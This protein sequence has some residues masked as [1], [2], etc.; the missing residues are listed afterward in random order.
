VCACA[1]VF[2]CV[3]RRFNYLLFCERE[4]EERSDAWM[5]EGEACRKRGNAAFAAGDFAAAIEAYNQAI[6]TC[7]PDDECAVLALGNRVQAHLSAAAA[8][9]SAS[10]TS[11]RERQLA[12]EDA[13]LLVAKRPAW[14]KAHF[15][16]ASA[17]AAQPGSEALRE[18]LLALHECERLQ[19]PAAPGADVQRLRK[20]LEGQCAASTAHVAGCPAVREG[21]VALRP[22]ADFA[23]RGRGVFA[24]KPV[25]APGEPIFV[26][27]PLVSHVEASAPDAYLLR[28]CAQC[29]RSKLTSDVAHTLLASPDAAPWPAPLVDWLR[30][31][32]SDT[33][34]QQMVPCPRCS[35]RFC[36]EECRDAALASHHS[37]LCPGG[38][39]AE[40]MAVYERRCKE[41][42][43]TNPLCIARIA[44]M[45]ASAVM[46]RHETLE[47]ALRPFTGFCWSPWVSEADEELAAL[48]HTALLQGGVPPAVV[49]AVA[50]ID[51]FRMLNGVLQRNASRVHPLCDLHT[52]LCAARGKTLSPEAVRALHASQWVAELTHGG[53]A[54]FAVANSINHS[55][56]PNVQFCSASN[57]HRLLV[58]STRPIPQDCELLVSYI[59]ESQPR[60]VRQQELRSKYLFSCHCD[61][62]KQEESA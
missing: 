52:F 51:A 10:A 4:R 26:E 53:T 34:A 47:E 31:V 12:L 45:V 2:V 54:L 13:R 25:P 35:A 6:A 23:Q 41:L 15:R 46:L 62:C 37:L 42:R 9:A 29:M 49:D 57:D 55:C 48:L 1:P 19:R 59:D 8:A 20:R 61:R 7:A 56:S 11:S 44:A 33:S 21:V 28:C 50:S 36:C 18:A 24:V 39:A 17:L 30:G 40:Q 38:A 16:L 5:T 43:L 60:A 32:E 27:E 22:C 3:L 14:P 58:V